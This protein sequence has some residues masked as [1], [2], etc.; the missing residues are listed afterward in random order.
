MRLKSLYI[1]DYKNIKNQF[2]DFSNNTG[3]IAL[4]GLN[5]SGKS[6]LLEAIGLIFNGI[7]N[8][9]QIPFDYTIVYEY[10][11]KEY[12]KK[13]YGAK[14]DGKR[15]K[16][17]DMVYPSTVIACYSGEDL[18]FWHMAFED[19]YMHYFKRAVDNKVLSPRLIYL[20]KYCWDIAFISLISS[21]KTEVKDF[22]K[23]IFDISD[24]E[25]VEVS[26]EFAKTNNFKRHRALTWIERI[27]KECLDINGKAEMK[28]LLSYDIPLLPNHNKERTLF[29][30]L[31]LLSQPKKNSEK[32]NSINKYIT[33]IRINNNGIPL[34]SFSEGLKKLILV[35][36]ITNILGDTNSLLLFDEPDAH[37]H[38]ARKKDLLNSIESFRGQTIMTTHSPV[39]V[40][41]IHKRDRNNLFFMEQGTLVNSDYINNLI[42]LS[43][44]EIDYLNGSILLSAKK[45]LVTEGPY[46]KRY[47]EKAIDTLKLSYRQYER[48]DD[49]VV[50]ASGSA[51]NSLTFYEQVLK[52]QLSKYDKII[53]IFDYDSS[54]YDGW[55]KICNLK[56]KKIISL[57]Y[58]SDYTSELKTK[59]TITKTIMV[60]DLF[61]PE[62]YKVKVDSVKLDKKKTHKDFRCF[63]ENMASAIKT[64]IEN[65]YMNFN[66]EWYNG[67]KPVLDKLLD[68]F[69]LI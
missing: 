41:E 60:E 52:A 65:N 50:I 2:F 35:E 20:N 22:L 46:D 58:Q 63:S 67:F 28:S 51:G 13:K 29:N 30:Y 66:N 6:N 59:P 48:F 26:F 14:I 33:K 37:T 16:N 45:I 49:I 55:K 56:E 4:I 32:G 11:G 9:K 68:S 17:S 69:N 54:G 53:F 19:Y 38:I 44:G 31:Y 18:R 47:I 62:S 25:K 40:N 39:F 61:D 36:C 15:A 34:S 8:H 1:K 7:L 3:Y 24:L 42:D 12:S 57:F 23:N 10:D 64:Y 21:E 5:G 27:K 43:S